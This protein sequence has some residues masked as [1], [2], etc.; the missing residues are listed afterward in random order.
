MNEAPTIHPGHIGDLPEVMT[1]M[2]EAFDPAFGE[3]WTEAQCS[4]ILGMAGVWLTLARSAAAPAGFALSRIIFDEAELLLLAVRPGCRRQ[5]IGEALLRHTLADA[6]R[7]GA[8]RLH[9]EMREGNPAIALYNRAGFI[10]SGRRPG[11]YFGKSGRLFD[12][13]TLSYRYP[14]RKADE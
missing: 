10:K 14:A 2:A 11:Y 9:L 5:G 7:R 3:A 12:A 6:A 4:G 13:L 8:R 1:T